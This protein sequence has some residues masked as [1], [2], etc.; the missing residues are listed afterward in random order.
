L[1][2]KGRLEGAGLHP[3]LDDFPGGSDRGCGP[4][5][6]G[7]PPEPLSAPSAAGSN[8]VTIKR[9]RLDP[10]GNLIETDPPAQLPANEVVAL[11]PYGSLFFAA[12]PVLEAQLPAPADTSRNSVVILRLRGRTDLGT[13]FM[14]VLRRY[15]QALA[16][17][18]G[19]LVIVSASDR[20]QEQLRVTGVTDLIAAEN[21]YA[22]DERVGATLKRAYADAVAWIAQ[23]RGAA[24]ADAQ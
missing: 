17:C 20:I 24:E 21:I 14:D 5:H 13:T 15:A 4:S 1:A 6:G 12:A 10:E 7:K 22:G 3:W 9:W 2:P 18:G 19:K 8:Q 23:N 11:Q 16:A